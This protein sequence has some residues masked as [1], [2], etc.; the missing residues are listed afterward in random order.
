[1]YYNDVIDIESLRVQYHMSSIV[2]LLASSLRNGC[3]S[4]STLLPILSGQRVSYEAS[5]LAER[6]RKESWHNPSG[7]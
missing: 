4:G 6:G 2:S 5:L 3:E 1:M 7:D